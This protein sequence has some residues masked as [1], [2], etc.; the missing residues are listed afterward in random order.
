MMN[1]SVK[2]LTALRAAIDRNGGRTVGF[3]GKN[4]RKISFGREHT[5]DK[6]SQRR[7]AVHHRASNVGAAVAITI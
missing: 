7:I 3:V 6:L 4:S 1:A 2:L 5:H